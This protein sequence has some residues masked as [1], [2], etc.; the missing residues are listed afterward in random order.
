M[1]G[2]FFFCW[3]VSGWWQLKYF[4]YVHP[5]SLGGGNDPIWLIFFGN[6]LV[7]PPTRYVFLQYERDIICVYEIIWKLFNEETTYVKEPFGL[8][9]RIRSN[10]VM[11][12]I[13]SGGVGV[14][15]IEVEDVMWKMWWKQPS[16]S[17]TTP[18]DPPN[19]N[20]KNQGSEDPMVNIWG[21]IT[22]Q[23]EGNM[24]S[25]GSINSINPS[26]YAIC[27]PSLIEKNN[28]SETTNDWRFLKKSPGTWTACASVIKQRCSLGSDVKGGNFNELYPPETLTYPLKIDGWSRCISYWNSPFFGD[29]LTFRGG[30]TNHLQ[31]LNGSNAS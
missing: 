20:W 7:Q 12:S 24:G 6:G 3:M 11:F 17:F 9:A 8:D 22:P 5:R 1:R 16:P 30:I 21:P 19:P 25:N 13:F 23:N 10:E 27:K 15:L 31:Q 26:F 2:L 18:L 29:M 28:S 14:E 4:F